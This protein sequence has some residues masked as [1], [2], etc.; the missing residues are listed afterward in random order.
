MEGLVR[1]VVVPTV[2]MRRS[3]KVQQIAYN[4]IQVLISCAQLIQELLCR[5]CVKMQMKVPATLKMWV[6]ILNSEPILE[7]NLFLQ[8]T[9]LHEV[10]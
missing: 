1:D 10:A 5:P 9:L 3:T 2:M 6:S 4:V 8:A 7:I